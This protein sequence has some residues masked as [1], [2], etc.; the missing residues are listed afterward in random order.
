MTHAQI[1]RSFTIFSHAYGH[2]KWAIEG[3]EHDIIFGPAIGNPCP[4][5]D[6]RQRELVDM[7]WMCGSRDYGDYW[8]TFV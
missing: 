1:I 4:I 5:P 3:A 2:D 7:G 8:C 6:D